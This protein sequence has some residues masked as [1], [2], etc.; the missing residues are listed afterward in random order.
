ME[1][2]QRLREDEEGADRS[3]E[4]EVDLLVNF[5]PVADSSSV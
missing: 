1:D 3:M 2:G 4:A 5:L